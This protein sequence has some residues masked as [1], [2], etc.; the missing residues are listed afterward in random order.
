M[1]KYNGL[2]TGVPQNTA[3]ILSDKDVDKIKEKTL[4]SYFSQS[5]STSLSNYCN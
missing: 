2:E 1:S 3:A 5:R 4:F